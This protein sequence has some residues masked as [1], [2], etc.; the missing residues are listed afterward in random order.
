MHYFEAESQK[1][2]CGGGC[3]PPQH[4]PS[5]NSTS[6]GACSASP[7]IYQPPQ[8]FFHNSHTGKIYSQITQ[9]EQVIKQDCPGQPPRMRAFSYAWSRDKDGGHAIRSIISKNPM[10]HANFMVLC[11]TEPE[12]LPIK[13]LHSGNKDFRPFLLL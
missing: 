13:V 1:F 4:H 9:E 11:F 8:L 12:L 3:P 10:Q 6:F 7:R 5:P 2:F